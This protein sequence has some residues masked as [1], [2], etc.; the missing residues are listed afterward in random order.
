M[1]KLK[2]RKRRWAEEEILMES[3]YTKI[4]STSTII[5]ELHFPSIKSN[6]NKSDHI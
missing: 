6:E 4:S 3:K 2:V 1:V 5:K